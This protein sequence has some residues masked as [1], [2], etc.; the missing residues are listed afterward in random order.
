MRFLLG[1]HLPP[2]A[3]NGKARGDLFLSV[4][5]LKG[6][7]SEFPK[8]VLPHDSRIGL[9]SEGYSM[10]FAHGEW[11]YPAPDYVCLARRVRDEIGSLWFASIQD[12]M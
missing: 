7:K 3:W 2:W 12:W 4:S 10:L 1:T 11:K 8:A 5:R 9:D 6:R